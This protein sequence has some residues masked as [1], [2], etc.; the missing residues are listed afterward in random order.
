MVECIG[1]FIEQF[2]YCEKEL[3]TKVTGVAFYVN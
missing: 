3:E 2:G 1:E